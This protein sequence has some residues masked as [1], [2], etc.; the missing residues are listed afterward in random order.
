LSQRGVGVADTARRAQLERKFQTLYAEYF[1]ALEFNAY[2]MP[3][4]FYPFNGEMVR[5]A[6][7]D[8]E[9]YQYAP[10][11]AVDS[12]R[13]NPFLAIERVHGVGV[14]DDQIRT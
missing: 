10:E 7:P 14:E 3:N 5:N 8:I 13:R 6:A 4:S 2:M 9:P 12:I 1:S 11:E